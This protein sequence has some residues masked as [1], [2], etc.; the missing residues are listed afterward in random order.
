M[1]RQSGNL[2]T[3][4]FFLFVEVFLSLGLLIPLTPSLLT[5]FVDKGVTKCPSPAAALISQDLTNSEH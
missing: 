1:L 5:D 3:Y 2:C 4:A